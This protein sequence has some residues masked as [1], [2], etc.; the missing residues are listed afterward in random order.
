MKFHRLSSCPVSVS[1]FKKK[2]K[3]TIKIHP[4]TTCPLLY[5]H[6]KK[7]KKKKK[8]NSLFTVKD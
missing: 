8:T 6:L 5:T 2:N 4:P 3:T 7:K 1:T